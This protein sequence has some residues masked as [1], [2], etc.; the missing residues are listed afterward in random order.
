MSYERSDEEFPAFH[1]PG[2]A[3]VGFQMLGDAPE[4]YV[5]PLGNLTSSD[6][7]YGAIQALMTALQFP[8]VTEQSAVDELF[9]PERQRRMYLASKAGAELIRQEGIA[10]AVYLDRSARYIRVGIRAYEKLAYPD[11]P[12]L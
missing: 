2:L 12:P 6:D 4:G 3:G 1:L 9:T 8:P 11:E 7:L 5:G 10:D